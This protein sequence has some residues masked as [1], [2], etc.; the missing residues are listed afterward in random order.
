LRYFVVGTAGHVDHGKTSL[1]KALTG[2]DCD[3]LKEEKQRG[4]TIDIGFAYFNLSNGD[5]VEIIDVP[6]HE[7]FIKNM[8]AGAGVIDA[9][10][11]VVAANEGVMPQ[12]REHL[13][14]LTLLGI[15]E[16]IVVINKIDLVDEQWL[17]MVKDQL[18]ELLKGTFLE[19]KPLIHV[20]SITGKGIDE[21]KIRLETIFSG[22]KPKDETFAFRLPIDRVFSKEGSGTIITGTIT[23]GML[24]LGEEIELLPQKKTVRVR[25]IGSHNKKIETAVAGQ[26][27]GLNL[28]GVKKEEL[29]RGNVLA[30]PGYLTSSELLDVRVRLLNSSPKPLKNTNRIRLYLGTGEYIGRAVLLDAQEIKP[31]QSGLVQFR[32]ETRLSCVKQERFV[33]R[34]YSPMVTVGGGEVINPNPKRHRRFDQKS[35]QELLGFEKINEK[36]LGQAQAFLEMTSLKEDILTGLSRL[37]KKYPL[38]SNIPKQEL[39]S[40]L[41]KKSEDNLFENALKELNSENRLFLKFDRVNLPDHKVSLKPQHDRINAAIEE[42][43]SKK[44]FSPPDLRGIKEILRDKQALIEEALSYL[45]ENGKVVMISEEIMLNRQAVQDAGSLLRQYLIQ[46][47]EITVSE[48]AKLLGSSRKYALPILQYF[49]GSGLTRRVGDKRVLAH[50]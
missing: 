2:I 7:R 37:H 20:S 8:L 45:T 22:S 21:L 11:L 16:G 5:C 10:L 9:V 48:F 35:I 1:I 49:D 41:S 6:G 23:S 4:M 25:Q 15:K 27:V 36:E 40:S 43:L 26:R 31:G 24:K 19:G 39:K 42:M 29:V 50:E 13:D 33:I 44:P 34:L 38:K 14:I 46:K 3:R 18:K 32:L 47:K 28:V 30:K 12:T 17:V